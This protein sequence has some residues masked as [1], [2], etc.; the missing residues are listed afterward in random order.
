MLHVPAIRSSAVECTLCHLDRLLL[1]V[2]QFAFVSVG[3]S[4]AVGLV[5]LLIVFVV[6]NCCWLDQRSVSLVAGNER[7]MAWLMFVF[8]LLAVACLS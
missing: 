7:L 6:P 4:E 1:V 3:Y 8:R 2:Y 5:V